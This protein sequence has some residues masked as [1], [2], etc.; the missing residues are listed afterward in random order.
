M[1][2]LFFSNNKKKLNE[3]RGLFFKQKIKIIDLN[4]FPKVV[5]PKENGRT[6]AENAKIKSKYGYNQ[7]KIPCFS[8]D[9][10]ICINA[11][12]GRPGVKSKRYFSNFKN[13]K[14][15]FNHIISN[16]KHFQNFDAYFITT[17]C[18]TLKKGH[19][20]FFEG[21]ICGKISNRPKG[22]NGFGYDPIF[23]P[24]YEKKTFAEMSIYKKNQLSH[25][26]I[27]IRKMINF[28]SS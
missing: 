14:E 1:N 12:K 7:F 11:L 18:L 3:L 25:R 27:A 19:Y 4:N 20:I 28:L 24:K 15:L 17:I 22:V 6:F 8:D 16:A 21:K 9:S 26:A 2:L 23:I 10:G 13:K 5:E